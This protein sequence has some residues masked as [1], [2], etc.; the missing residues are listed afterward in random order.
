MPAAQTGVFIGI[1]WTEYHRLAQD[2][3]L[4]VS[5][6]TAQGAVL[7][8][9]P[10]RVAFHHGLKGPALSVD[11]AC[12]SSL[13]ALNAAAE[14]LA[15][16]AAAVCDAALAGGINMV[17]APATTAMF[18][19]AGMLSA[20]GRC[21]ALDAAADGY[22]RSEAAAVLLLSTACR[23]VEGLDGG[24]GDAHA[25]PAT[26]LAVLVGTAVNQ[27]GR[28]SSLTAPNGPSQQAVVRAA[29]AT[30]GAGPRA[31]TALQLHGTGTGLGDPIELGAV[32]ELLA[33]GRGPGAGTLRL[34]ASK[35]QLGHSEPASGIMGLAQ[36][37]QASS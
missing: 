21:K 31:V 3:G 2:A 7:S 36:L 15:R 8:V 13:V 6:Y 28:A 24:A 11:T 25:P 29:L 18:Q 17:L 19:K 35:S 10:G 14:G 26:P 16:P 34:L 12:S 37:H 33:A 27:G 9:C 4:P 1:S 22:V 23:A 32:A 5:A 20:D 30:A